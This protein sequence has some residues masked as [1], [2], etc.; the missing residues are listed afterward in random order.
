MSNK[1]TA[2]FQSRLI[3]RLDIQV[4][5]MMES[6]GQLIAAAKINAADSEEVDE[7]G[8]KTDLASV[9]KE[10][11]ELQ[12][13]TKA[14]IKG[15]ENLLKLLAELKELIMLNDVGTQMSV[16]KERKS[17]CL[18]ETGKVMKSLAD[19]QNELAEHLHKLENVYY[20]HPKKTLGEQ[21][22]SESVS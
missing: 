6:Y 3:R 5:T 1:D 15:A 20:S 13:R 11:F 2:T 4:R 22:T 8:Q 10:E 18:Q 9:S 17:L 19:V 21:E 14:L 16:V 12:V 7:A